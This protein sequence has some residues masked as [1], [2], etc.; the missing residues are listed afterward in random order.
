MTLLNKNLKVLEMKSLLRVVACLSLC[1]SLNSLGALY[2]VNFT[3]E[4]SN[5]NE[6]LGTIE[7]ETKGNYNFHSDR[8]FNGQSFNGFVVIDSS[9]APGSTLLNNPNK[10]IYNSVIAKYLDIGGHIYSDYTYSSFTQI[11]N[12]SGNIDNFS[13]GGNTYVRPFYM[14]PGADLSSF[15]LSLR[16]HDQSFFSST[17]L[18]GAINQLKNG[19]L[20]EFEYSAL[21]FLHKSSGED[22]INK[23]LFIEGQVN[24]LSVSEVPLPA[25][26]YLFLSGLVGLGLMRGRN[27]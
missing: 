13:T 21:G 22:V 16:D 2:K 27:V 17:N 12:N 3:G 23:Y 7:S 6:Y 1:V 26:I 19:T 18:L 5:I 10:D 11:W 14:G 9:A 4:V 20:S 8:Y 24:T 25:G 15:K